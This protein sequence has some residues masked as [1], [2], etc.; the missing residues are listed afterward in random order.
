MLNGEGERFMERYDP[1]PWSSPPRRSWPSPARWRS[2]KAA[3][4]P[5]RVYFAL[6]HLTPDGVDF[7]WSKFVEFLDQ[8]G[9]K[10]SE[11]RK[12]LPR[13]LELAKT[14]DL[15]WGT[16]CTSWWRHQ[17]N[18]RTETGVPGLYAAG[19]CSGGLWGSVRVASATT[20]VGAQGRIAGEACRT[21]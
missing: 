18:E 11:F 5:R 20:Q 6:K 16:R 14:Q 17:V 10:R 7:V 3:A 19:E 13:L 8:N 9:D 12:L 4:P 2:R 21:T 15:E 1:P